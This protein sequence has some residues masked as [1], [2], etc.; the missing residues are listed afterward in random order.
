MKTLPL[1]IVADRGAIKAFTPNGERPGSVPQ[2]ADEIRIDEAHHR[3]QDT[4]TDQAGS[5]PK[6]GTGFQGNSTA[7]RMHLDTEKQTR[8]L[9]QIGQHLNELL[10]THQPR[11]WGFAAPSEIN[12]SILHH[13]AP[14]WKDSLEVNLPK[15]LIKESPA[16]LRSHFDAAMA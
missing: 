3:Y 15:D 13:L 11:R 7:E 2:L 9:R 16:S 12:A 4:F 5:F 6:G 14:Q 8:I 1:F 10:A